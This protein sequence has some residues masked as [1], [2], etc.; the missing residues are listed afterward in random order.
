[1]YINRAVYVFDGENSFIFRVDLDDYEEIET[2]TEIG[3]QPDDDQYLG[4]ERWKKCHFLAKNKPFF[5]TFFCW[6]MISDKKENFL[7]YL[8]I[9]RS[10]NFNP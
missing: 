6:N 8:K 1:M 7:K 4:C 9:F 2:I 3:L 10:R 5:H